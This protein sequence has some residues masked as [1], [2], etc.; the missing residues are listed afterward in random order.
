VNGH[1]FVMTFSGQFFVSV[2]PPFKLA[3]KSFVGTAFGGE[4]FSSNPI[5][6]VCDRGN[7]ILP[8]YNNGSISAS[9][10]TIPAAVPQTALQPITAHI[11]N[12]LATF[13]GLYIN[14]AGYPYQIQFSFSGGAFP[15]PSIIS[16]KFDVAV[17]KSVAVGYFSNST[18]I[19][20]ST[21]YAGEYIA[22]SP[23]LKLLDSG[24]NFVSSDNSTAI[25]IAIQANPTNATIG[26]EQYTFVVA[27]HGVVRFHGIKTR[28]KLYIAF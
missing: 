4:P 19:S 18:S 25:K 12:G 1:P 23:I 6:A 7:N 8:T 22:N 3:L 26:P 10:I 5:V 28:V 2:G 16:R 21:I 14:E 20:A 13:R 11:I 27:H 9:L 17:G 24:G 15:F